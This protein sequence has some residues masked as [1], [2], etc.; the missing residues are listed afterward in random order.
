MI[1]FTNTKYF[2]TNVSFSKKNF[3]V[4]TLHASDNIIQLDAIFCETP[5]KSEYFSFP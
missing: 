2:N 5:N 4:K 1:A 3:L